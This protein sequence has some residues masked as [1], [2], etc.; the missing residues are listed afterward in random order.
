MYSSQLSNFQLL[1]FVS[2]FIYLLID[3]FL[4]LTRAAVVR[5][6]WLED[7]FQFFPWGFEFLYQAAHVTSLA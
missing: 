6:H 7:T 5:L 3:F 1:F 4:A 2:Y